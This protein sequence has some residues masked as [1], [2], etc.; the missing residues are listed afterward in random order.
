MV[1][2]EYM[3]KKG[4]ALTALI[5]VAA[6]VAIIGGGLVYY[7]KTN[8]S[9]NP[10]EVLPSQKQEQVSGNFPQ[11]QKQGIDNSKQA[12]KRDAAIGVSATGVVNGK[13]SVPMK[14]SFDGRSETISGV[15]LRLV[16][17]YSGNDTVKVSSLQIDPQ[18]LASKGWSC[19][20]RTAVSAANKVTVDLS[21]IN[22]SITGYSSTGPTQLATFDLVNESGVFGPEVKMNIDQSVSAITR[23]SDG[24]NVLTS[25]GQLVVQ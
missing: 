22:T 16:Y 3:S 2:S 19:P 9:A 20:V 25:E 8:M 4:F 1:H 6:V 15:A 5:V 7:L 14:V 17:E 10:Q 12:T 23:K 18:L 24:K 11:Q 13:K 21:C